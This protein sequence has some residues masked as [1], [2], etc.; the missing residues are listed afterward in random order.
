MKHI[1][2][3]VLGVAALT[4]ALWADPPARVGR[5]SYVDG[6]V[7]FTSAVGQALET[8]TLNYPLTTGNQLSTAAGARAEVQ[9][10]SAAV[11]LAPDTGVTFETID[12][13]A[14]QIR[15]D[16]GVISVSLHRLGKD[17]SFQ[18]DTQTAGISLA[19]PGRYRI[20]QMQSGE[21]TI[22]TRSGDAEVTGGQAAFHVFSGQ[23]ADIPGSGPEANQISS[24]PAPDA[25]DSWVAD[26]DSRMSGRTSTR[27]ASSEMD[28]VQDLDDYGHWTVVAGYGPLWIP[29]A[30]PI[31]W[32][33]YT[34]GQWVWVA[35]WGW[36]WVDDEPWGFAPFHYG[37]WVLY[38]GA[39]CWVPG[40]IVVR[41][42]YAPALVRW[43]G[44]P[45]PRGIA[46]SRAHVTWVPL[47]PRQV[48]RPPY[49]ASATYLRAVNGGV[50][51]RPRAP[52]R[53]SFT[54]G[55]FARPVSP[56]RGYMPA[57][58][59]QPVLPR[60]DA[61]PLFVPHRN[62]QWA[63]QPPQPAYA[64]PEA[65]HGRRWPPPAYGDQDPWLL[66]R[67]GR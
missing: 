26:R 13:Q 45:P 67:P 8:A 52:F 19:A 29:Q 10:G 6:V 4:A 46:P 53:P 31:G 40:P 56:D 63:G 22:V 16:K 51:Y 5:L 21:A 12:D 15:L 65:D 20:D 55:T 64:G 17:Q 48:F 34:F 58:P 2:L 32:A 3:S 25:W 62:P 9:I 61:R 47:Q 30:V 66:K 24:A 50:V 14:V 39:W 42:V 28:G 49:H 18:V 36:T 38:T 44:G 41:P 43:V 27:Y 59:M 7:S 35:P 37:R 33:P 11:R 60:Q 54:T 57:R 23:S 1:L